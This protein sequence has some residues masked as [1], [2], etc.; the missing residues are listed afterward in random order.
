MIENYRTGRIWNVFMRHPAVQRGLVRAGFV[1][2]AGEKNGQP[3]PYVVPQA[4]QPEAQPA[5]PD[6][7][8]HPPNQ[9]HSLHN[10]AHDSVCVGRVSVRTLGPTRLI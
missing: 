2:V 10:N 5:H 7:V 1:P 9:R 3:I 4:P 8:P 6:M